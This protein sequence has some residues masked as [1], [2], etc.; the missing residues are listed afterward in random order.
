MG[1]TTFGLTG[2]LFGLVGVDEINAIIHNNKEGHSSFGNSKHHK[3]YLYHC[4]QCSLN[5]VHIELCDCYEID[6]IHLH[7]PLCCLAFLI[8]HNRVC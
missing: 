7:S 2:F 6:N 4:L 5:F 3:V 8:W 1:I